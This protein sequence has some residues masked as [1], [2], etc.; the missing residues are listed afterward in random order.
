MKSFSVEQLNLLCSLQPEHYVK[1]CCFNASW[2]VLSAVPVSLCFINWMALNQSQSG[3]VWCWLSDD[4]STLEPVCREWSWPWLEESVLTVSPFFPFF[5][6]FFFKGFF[7]PFFFFILFFLPLK[8]VDPWR[9]VVIASDM[10]YHFQ[11]DPFILGCDGRMQCFSDVWP[12]RLLQVCSLLS[13][14]G[15]NTTVLNLA[16]LRSAV[17]FT[18]GSGGG[19]MKLMLQFSHQF[20]RLETIWVVPCRKVTQ[21]IHEILFGS[22]M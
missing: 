15:T 17:H 9:L 20:L 16:Y 12:H 5:F 2:A 11:R 13:S 3:D 10:M 19:L 1:L 22:Y 4:D 21:E 6:F 7:F 8:A 18:F 14:S